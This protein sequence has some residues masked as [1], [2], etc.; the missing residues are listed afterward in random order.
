M[1]FFK[2]FLPFVLI[3]LALGV[4]AL[5]YKDQAEPGIRQYVSPAEPCRTPLRYAVGPVDPRF[6]ISPEKLR[7]ILG[8]AES[9][10][11]K[12]SGLNIFEYSPEAELKVRLAYDERQQQT[13]EAEQIEQSLNNLDAQRAL[14]EK[15]Q[16]AVSSEYDRKFSLFK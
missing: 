5:K 15:Q 13:Y 9:L 6:N 11:E 2:K 1:R 3:V 12:S 14:L 4:A 10:W 8:E 16:S 7:E